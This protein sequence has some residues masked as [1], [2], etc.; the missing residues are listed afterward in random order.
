MR[1]T[2]RKHR[3]ESGAV[4]AARLLPQDSTAS[5]RRKMPDPRTRPDLRRF[6][7]GAT[8]F[9]PV[10]PSVS[11]HARPFARSV[12]ALHSTTSALLTR[13]TEPRTAV[14]REAAYGIAADKLLTAGRE[15]H[16]IWRT[17]VRA[18]RPM[19]DRGSFCGSTA[20]PFS[21]V[22]GLF[23][24]LMCADEP[25][26]LRYWLWYT[27]GR[28]VHH[29]R[30]VIVRIDRAWPWAT[31]LVRAFTRLWALPLLTDSHGRSRPARL[32]AGYGPCPK[33]QP[34]SAATVRLGSRSGVRAYQARFRANSL[35]GAGSVYPNLSRTCAPCRY[36]S[37]SMR[38]KPSA[39]AT[40]SIRLNA[41]QTYIASIAPSWLTPVTRSARM[42]S[43]PTS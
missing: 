37:S 4:V 2:D 38:S 41:K 30:R 13:V 18:R 16:S 26:T 1:A 28:L 11:G 14:R 35:R 32:P 17:S 27:A 5:P 29:A 21:K 39:S 23:T 33:F 19:A 24:V 34:S 22:E 8:G 43:A 15:L 10:T 31:A 20:G 25:K 40:R 3:R 9:E 36:P 6:V 7:V 42:S 12:V